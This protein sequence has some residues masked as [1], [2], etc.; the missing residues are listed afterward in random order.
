M[1]G[2]LVRLLGVDLGAGDPYLSLG[3]CLGGDVPHVHHG[4]REGVAEGGRAGR[5]APDRAI[6]AAAVEEL[7]VGV[8]EALMRHQVAEVGV[9]ECGG[10]RRVQRRQRGVAAAVGRPGA[11]GLQRRRECGVDVGVVVDVV[12]EEAALRLP[13]RVPP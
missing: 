10:R 3:P 4:R 11:V 8:Q 1:H 7:L 9:V 5:E 2:R 6:R 13:D 12:A